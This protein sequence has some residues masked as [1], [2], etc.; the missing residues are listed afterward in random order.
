MALDNSSMAIKAA[1]RQIMLRDM[2]EKDVPP[3]II[4]TNG[5]VGEVYLNCYPSIETG[6]VFEK[7]EKKAEALATQRPGWAIYASD[8]VSA[9]TQNLCSWVPCTVLDVDPYGASWPI[10]N[11]FFLSERDFQPWMWIAGTDG[12]RKRLQIIGGWKEGYLQPYVLEYGNNLYPIYLELCPKILAEIVLNAGYLVDRFWGKY[13]G[14]N[15]GMVD[16]LARLRR[17]QC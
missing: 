13:A 2:A 11:A 6:T 8:C 14:K 4:E 1:F 5:G 12:L 15:D 10:L 16:Y 3:I 17:T 7:D 9:L